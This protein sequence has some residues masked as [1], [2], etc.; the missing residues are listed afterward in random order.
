M[1]S[2]CRCTNVGR[3]LFITLSLAA[4]LLMG[5]WV[6]AQEAPKQLKTNEP[7]QIAGEQVLILG[8]GFT[9]NEVIQL[10]VKHADGTAEPGMGHAAFSVVA[11]ADGA[12]VTPWVIRP[13]DAQ[14]DQ[15]QVTS[16]GLTTGV[17]KATTSFDRTVAVCTDK[18]AYGPTE[19]A[20]ITGTGFLPGEGVTLQVIH[21]DGE[22]E[23]NAGHAP[24][25]VTAA[26]AGN[27]NSSVPMNPTDSVGNEFILKASGADSGLGAGAAIM[28]ALACPPYPLP[29]PV[30][31]T[32]LPSATC[33]PNL[34]SC[35]ANDVVTTVVSANPIGNDVCG[36]RDDFL[37]L[38]FTVKFDSTA[39]QR[40]DLGI[41]LSEDGGT[42]TNGA[43]N[44][45]PTALVCGGLAPQIGDGDG[46]ADTSDCDSDRF[47]DLDPDHHSGNAGD[48]CGDLQENAGPVF[49]TVTATVSC[50]TVDENLHLKVPSC[51]VWEQNAQHQVPCTT[52]SQAGTG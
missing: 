17:I 41:F 37:S 52:L 48:T 1:P 32:A 28:D 44:T 25:V 47:L 18:F 21:N 27:I 6:A 4:C 20:L 35:T 34:N 40:Y 42:V 8:T 38:Q 3:S 29:D 26:A 39:N 50:A 36:T 23:P 45:P 46:N 12:F 14:G 7:G 10:D 43:G 51:R 22:A 9:P 31:P 15:F 30:V 49:L 11:G 13:E 2:E 16:R 19:S 24:W 33:P 5:G